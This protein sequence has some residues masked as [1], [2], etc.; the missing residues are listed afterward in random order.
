MEQAADFKS[1]R[2]ENVVWEESQERAGSEE[3]AGKVA[4]EV[5][6]SLEVSGESLEVGE[7]FCRCFLSKVRS[8]SQCSTRDAPRALVGALGEMK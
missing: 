4:G 1:E 3:S 6:E 8:G 7:V 2:E 5:Q